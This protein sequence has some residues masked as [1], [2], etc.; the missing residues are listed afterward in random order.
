MTGMDPLLVVF[1]FGVGVLV[2]TTGMGGGSLMTPLLILLFGIK[3]VVA[4]G[5]D[6]AYAAVT[7]TV[8]G[9]RH[10]HKGTVQLNIAGWL[11][12]GSVPGALAG[13][14]LLE[15]LDLEDD[16][17]LAI[18][19]GLVLTGALILARALVL[20]GEGER[21]EIALDRRH[22]AFAAVLGLSV[23]TL[24][25]V[26]SAGSGTLIAVGLILGFRLTPRRV[27]GT[28]VAHA[29]V[30]L[31]AAA[32]AHLIS[33]N[34]NLALA[35]TLLLGS[36]PGVWVGTNLST[37]LPERGLRPALGIVMFTSGLALLTKAGIGIPAIALVADPAAARPR[38]LR[39]PAPRG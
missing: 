32:F 36:I 26:T 3:P 9:I 28:D 11:A 30:L 27:V 22:K 23:G 39:D 10:F 12:V 33:G 6:L 29:A 35:G 7:K 14:A 38:V 5:T 19:V 37:R 16:L 13:V 34:V 1:G 21:E 17:I 31:W 24:L 18:A 8:G 4:V 15:L 2:G 20:T 25:G